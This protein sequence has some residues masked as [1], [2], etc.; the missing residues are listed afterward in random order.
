MVGVRRPGAPGIYLGA[1]HTRAGAKISALGLKVRN[2]CTYHGVAINVDMDLA[3]FTGIN[4]CGY[5]G[6]D[7]VD[8][9]GIGVHTRVDAV[10]MCFA[11][12]LAMLA[13]A[14]PNRR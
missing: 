8:L 6:L 9:A 1:P 5:A 10:G 13:A 11:T 2:G 12:E 3:P 7:T 14:S 4:P